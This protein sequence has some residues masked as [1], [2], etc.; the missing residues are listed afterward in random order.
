[1]QN[2]IEI[3]PINPAYKLRE[4]IFECFKSIDHELPITDGWGTS[5]EDAIIIDKNDPV[6][7]AGLPFDG[8]LKRHNELLKHCEMDFWFDVTSFYK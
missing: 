6:V 8:V 1:M 3:Y 4:V 7:T 2:Q 5:K